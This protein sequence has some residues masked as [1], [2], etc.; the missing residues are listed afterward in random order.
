MEHQCSQ[1]LRKIYDKQYVSYI[2]LILYYLIYLF[3]FAIIV[4]CDIH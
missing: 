4:L 3:H 2:S 1:F